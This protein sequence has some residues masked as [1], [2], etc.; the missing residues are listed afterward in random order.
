M[1]Y[2][3]RARVYYRPTNEVIRSFA[4]KSNTPLVDLEAV[5]MKPCPTESCPKFLFGDNHPTAAGHAIVAEAVR[6]HL[7][8][9]VR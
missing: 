9:R 1:T 7:A 2:P 8:S 5:F 6:D 3:A 4:I